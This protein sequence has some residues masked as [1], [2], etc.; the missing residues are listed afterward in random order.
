M[1]VLAVDLRDEV[2][3]L[4]ESVFLRAPVELVSP[5][6][7]DLL[8]VAKVGS[9]VPARVGDLI[10][11]TG[12]GQSFAQIVEDRFRRLDAKGSNLVARH[13]GERYCAGSTRGSAD[14]GSEFGGSGGDSG[15]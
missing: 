10:G 8:Q 4:V 12:A 3:P 6:V 15:S 1:H 13:D 9:V 2:R 11:P 14:G 5:V 7:A